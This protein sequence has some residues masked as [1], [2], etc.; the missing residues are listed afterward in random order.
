MMMMMIVFT[1]KR[2]DK[3]AKLKIKNKNTK[4]IAR[5]LRLHVAVGE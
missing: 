1:Y 4:V 2:N 3:L 5:A